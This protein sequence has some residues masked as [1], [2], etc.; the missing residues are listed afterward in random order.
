MAGNN[1]IYIPGYRIIMRPLYLLL[2]LLQRSREEETQKE[3]ISF[4]KH[5]S[6]LK[7]ERGTKEKRPSNEKEWRRVYTYAVVYP[8]NRRCVINENEK[9]KKKVLQYDLGKTFVFPQW[10]LLFL[11][12]YNIIYRLVPSSFFRVFLF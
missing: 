10:T 6:R 4:Q 7:S 12:P 5:R 2:L 8:R 1:E 11:L 9:R 3:S